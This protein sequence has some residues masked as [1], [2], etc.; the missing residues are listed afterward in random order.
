MLKFDIAFDDND[1]TRKV[2]EIISSMNEVKTVVDIGAHTGESSTLCLFNAMKD[3]PVKK[4]YA[5][6][7]QTFAYEKLKKMYE[8]YEWIIPVNR[9][10][11][12]KDDYNTEEEVRYFYDHYF[13]SLNRMPFSE[14]MR[15]E[16][17]E[18][19]YIQN[20]PENGL[21]WI[22]NDNG[23][24]PDAFFMDGSSYT[25]TYTKE[26][27]KYYGTKVIML[28][29]T[30]CM[31]NLQIREHL[32]KDTTYDCYYDDQNFRFGVSIFVKK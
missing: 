26:F 4:L 1:F 32:L 6:E 3:K 10:T 25:S 9:I 7:P 5:L 13:G 28:D 15:V 14:V 23:C 21:D 24:L 22:I 18:I 16:R 12:T 11:L 29:D 19:K 20:I 30:R 27:P 2:T 17:E 31:K 8:E